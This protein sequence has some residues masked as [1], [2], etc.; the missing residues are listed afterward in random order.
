MSFKGWRTPSGLLDRASFIDSPHFSL[1]L[2]FGAEAGSLG[3]ITTGARHKKFGS[4]E[5]AQAFVDVQDVPS[6][7]RTRASVANA[8]APAASSAA[9]I[10]N[11]AGPRA[12]RYKHEPAGREE[13][14]DEVGA[15]VVYCDGACRGNGQPGSVAGLGVWWGHDDPRNISERCP[16]DQTNNRAELCAIVRV[17][18]TTSASKGTLIIKTDS[19]YSIQCFQSWIPKWR[20]NGF[21]ASTGGPVKNQPLIKYLDALLTYHANSGHTIKLKHVKGHAGI[22]GNEGADRLAVAGTAFPKLEERDWKRDEDEVIAKMRPEIPG[23]LDEYADCLLD[24][25]EAANCDETPTTREV[26]T[27][28]PSPTKTV[29]KKTPQRQETKPP[30][31]NSSGKNPSRPP[32]KIADPRLPTAPSQQEY[33]GGLLSDD[34]LLILG[35]DGNFDS[36]F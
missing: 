16:G 34:E 13:H 18:E 11:P 9:V 19:S 15:D 14:E 7:H 33:A 8:T 5:D 30:L 20:A 35:K 17:L 25:E 22:P 21:R 32:A 4:I 28:P 26:P 27:T 3:F 24:D 36:D 23:D 29:V 10:E 1:A 31:A 12:T 6:P 2:S